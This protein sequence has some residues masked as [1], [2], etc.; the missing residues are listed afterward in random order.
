MWVAPVSKQAVDPEKEDNADVK[1]GLFIVKDIKIL[2][3]GTRH[4]LIR[5]PPIT[6]VWSAA[7]LAAAEKVVLSLPIFR[8]FEL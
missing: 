6:A 3:R 7:F 5:D 1:F 8:H 2:V 4:S